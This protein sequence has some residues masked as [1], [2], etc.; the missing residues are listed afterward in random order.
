MQSLHQG[1]KVKAPIHEDEKL[2]VEDPPIG[3][4]PRQRRDDLGEI[5]V[6]RSPVAAAQL[7][8]VTVA[9]GNAAKPIPLGLEEVAVLGQLANEPR[10]HRFESI[11]RHAF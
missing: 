2:A 11:E 3:R 7:D 1:R 10:K 5:A 8:A 4:N 6:K 9:A